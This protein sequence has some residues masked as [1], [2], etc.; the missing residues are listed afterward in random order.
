M[1]ARTEVHFMA[2]YNNPQPSLKN[3]GGKT[4]YELLVY[5]THDLAEQLNDTFG[6]ALRRYMKACGIGT[7]KLARITG[8]PKSTLSRYTH[9]EGKFKKSYIYAIFIALR[10]RTCQQRH[11]LVLIER[12]MPDECGKNRNRA[13]IIREYLDGCYYDDKYT[14]AALNRLL[15]SKGYKQ[16][17]P[18]ISDKEDKP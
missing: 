7:N 5:G 14:V 8:I 11:L 12:T 15:G 6:S 18:L 17:T 2:T 4:D 10:L 1:D 13:Y 9:G 16:L 3:N